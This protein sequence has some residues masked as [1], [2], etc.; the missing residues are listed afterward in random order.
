M[1]A[2]SS[3]QSTFPSSVRVVKG[4]YSPE[5]LASALKGI[6][7]IVMTISTFAVEQQNMIVEAAAKAGVKRLIPS[8][9]G[10]VS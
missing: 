1:L 10:S 7:A 6:D 2:R 9:F 8:E 4:D 3:S 5:F